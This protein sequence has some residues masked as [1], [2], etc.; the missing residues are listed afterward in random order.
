MGHTA[1]GTTVHRTTTETR[2]SGRSRGGRATG[3][4]GAPVRRALAAALVAA[5]STLVVV[6]APPAL[7][8]D[9]LQS[10]VSGQGVTIG[11]ADPNTVVS[12]DGKQTW[13][14]AYVVAA[15][16]QH[17][18]DR[19]FPEA[20]VSP[21]A[22]W[23]NCE[24]DFR[25]CVWENVWYRTFIVLPDRDDLSL[26][27]RVLADNAATPYI[28]GVKAG[29]RF[30]SYGS[31][32]VDPSLLHPGVNTFDMY[33]EDWGGLT[34]FRWELYGTL[35]AS[36]N[37]D[38]DQ[39]GKI[40]EPS[41]TAPTV[42]VTGVADGDSY[43]IGAVPAA[44]CA[45]SDAEDGTSSPAADVSA[46]TGLLA[47][48]GVGSQTATCSVTD[49]GGLSA[50]ASATYSVVDTGAPTLSGAPTTSPNAAGWYSAPVT[51]R[52]TA[53]DD[54]SGIDP[55]AKPADEVLSGD[56]TGQTASA[57]VVDRAG[58]TTEAISAPPVN[59]DRTAPDVGFTGATSYGLLDTVDISCS[60][61]DAL[62]GVASST[63]PS[64]SGDAWSFGPGVH[65]L[66]ASATDVAGNSESA[67]TSFQVDATAS[68]L[69]GLV[70][71]FTDHKGTRTSLCAHLTNFERSSSRG[72]AG[73]A[74]AQLD[75]F[76][77]EATARSGKQLTATQVAVLIGWANTL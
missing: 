9:H 37:P 29:D 21:D 6:A 22:N 14:P 64:A 40:D 30:E 47:D 43:E 11:D 8:T 61:T 4:R 24:A 17:P 73:P 72:K 36:A 62:S 42:A 19:W 51:I 23:I 60:A 12:R 57:F 5:A 2:R 65:D 13:Q 34:G 75:A 45:A 54:G 53:D 18:F 31:V 48:F 3:T 35:D 58:N 16:G 10:R 69:C 26:S 1:R 39:D 76:R 28:N 49:A 50:S 74:A 46:L 68:S 20:G 15:G 25:A 77:N 32:D 71:V 67:T 70:H 38:P 63:C 66:D 7:A 59:I 56:G 41:N 55:A 33:F 52:W 44:G 27:F